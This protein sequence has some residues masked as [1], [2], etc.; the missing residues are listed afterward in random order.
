V[1]G[2]RTR[3]FGVVPLVALAGA[4]LGACGAEEN[5]TRAI[6]TTRVE[7][8]QDVRWDVTTQDRLPTMMPGAPAGG[9]GAGA[10]KT[11]TSLDAMSAPGA[12]DG[13]SAVQGALHY[14]APEGWTEV[15]P[16]AMRNVN[17]QAGNPALECYVTMLAGDGGGPLPNVNRW[18]EQVG[19]PATSAAELAAMPRIPM[20]GAEGV[21]VEAVGADKTIIG[22]VASVGGRAVFVKLIGPSALAPQEKAHFVAFCGSLALGG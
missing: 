20:L 15:A 5:P 21:L 6:E 13:L 14:T 4:T 16:T 22:T 9:A 3:R 8:G 7:D 19:L 2:K 12:A 10:A 17:F 18:R 1:K 11:G